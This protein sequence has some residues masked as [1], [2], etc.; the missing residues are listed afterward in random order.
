MFRTPSGR[1]T[2]KKFFK[3]FFVFVF[4]LCFVNHSGLQGPR[5]VKTSWDQD[6]VGSRPRGIK[7]SWDQD[8]VGL[9]ILFSRAPSGVI[10]QNTNKKTQR[11]IGAKRRDVSRPFGAR[12]NQKIF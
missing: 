9:Y 5:G 11:N 6:L 7:T 2:I 12:N 10:N 1:E 8:L 4:C 3:I